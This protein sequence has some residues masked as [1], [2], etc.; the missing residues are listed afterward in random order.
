MGATDTHERAKEPEDLARLFVTRVDAGDIEG[1]VA[2]YEST[3]ILAL[4]NGARSR[5]TS[6]SR[7]LREVA[8]ESAAVRG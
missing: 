3:A 6:D 4:P 8:R 2:L 5:N 1:L 7:L